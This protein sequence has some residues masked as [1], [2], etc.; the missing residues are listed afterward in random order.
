MKQH[1]TSICI[2]VSLFQSQSFAKDGLCSDIGFEKRDINTVMGTRASAVGDFNKDGNPDIIGA[3]AQSYE[4]FIAF[5]GPSGF[6]TPVIMKTNDKLPGALVVSDFDKDG[7][8]DLAI[9]VSD[10]DGTLPG[11][12]IY[13]GDGSGAFTYKTAYGSGLYTTDILV[14][15]FDKD[16]NKDLATVSLNDG[17]YIYYGNGDATFSSKQLNKGSGNSMVAGDFD[18]D[19]STDFVV[20]SVGEHAVYLYY[21]VGNKDFKEKAVHVS[22]FDPYG[23]AAADINKDGFL[24]IVT[25]NTDNDDANNGSLDVFLSAKE[26]YEH[27]NIIAREL[28]HSY[29]SLNDFNGD[30]SIDVAVTNYVDNTLAILL[31]DSTGSFIL[32][33]TYETNSSPMKVISGDIDLD[34]KQDVVVPNSNNISV[35][36]GDC[37]VVTSTKDQEFRGPIKVYFGLAADKI[38][39]DASETIDAIHI[40]DVSGQQVAIMEPRS[41][42]AT[43]DFDKEGTYILRV[44]CRSSTTVQKLQIVK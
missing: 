24:D 7:N 43:I 38:Q 44:V 34:E 12:Y 29:L 30:R 4:V 19:G 25:S 13:T 31:G 6:G 35:F 3:S 27:K 22:N 11:V 42:Q 23:I 33:K 18:R 36:Y 9:T 37:S 17:V 40:T 32:E 15:D 21:N 10:V 14:D 39:I 1:F 8:Q 5:G 41:D 2:L 26:G 20:S 16:G 28:N